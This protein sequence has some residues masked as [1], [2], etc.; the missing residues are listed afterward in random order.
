M[1]WVYN[2]SPEAEASS[3]YRLIL[4]VCL[5]LTILMVITVSLRLFVRAKVGR[6]A[7]A[8]YVMVMSMVSIYIHSERN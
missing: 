2:A 5:S 6:L 8:D 1:G 7:A 3:Q 4:G